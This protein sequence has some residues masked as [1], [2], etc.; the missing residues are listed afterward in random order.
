VHILTECPYLENIF[1]MTH[2][3][4][5]TALAIAPLTLLLKDMSQEETSSTLLLQTQ[6]NYSL[7]CTYFRCGLVQTAPANSPT[8]IAGGVTQ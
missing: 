4:A 5:P 2:E 8:I 3:L 1:I 6:D 7:Y